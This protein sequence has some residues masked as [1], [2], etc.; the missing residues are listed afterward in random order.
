MSMTLQSGRQL[1]K[2]GMMLNSSLPRSQWINRLSSWGDWSRDKSRTLF[3]PHVRDPGVLEMQ[4]SSNEAISRGD[5]KFH[6]RDICCSHLW[7][8]KSQKWGQKKICWRPLDRR[9]TSLRWKWRWEPKSVNLTRMSFLLSTSTITSGSPSRN[10]TAG[11]STNR[12]T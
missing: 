6:E 4:V 7:E 1:G 10:S 5:Q 2:L 9:R 12:E 11:P 3:F 8:S